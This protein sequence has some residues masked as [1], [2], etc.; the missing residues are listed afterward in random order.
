[1]NQHRDSSVA[2]E[3]TIA[4]RVAEPLGDVT[5]RGRLP[6]GLGIAEVHD[7][8]HLLIPLGLVLAVIGLAALISIAHLMRERD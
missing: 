7:L 4:V 1:M 5:Q 8:L 2:T 6:P 3:R